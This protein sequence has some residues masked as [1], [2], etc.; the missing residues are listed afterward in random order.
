MI[1]II[2]AIDKKRGIGN[3]GKLLAYIQGTL[4]RFKKL[5]TGNTLS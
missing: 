2:V 5:T 1:T 4:T 3:K